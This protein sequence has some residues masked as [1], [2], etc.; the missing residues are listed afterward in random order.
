[1]VISIIFWAVVL[2]SWFLSSQRSCY[3]NQGYRITERYEQVIQEETSCLKM[4]G[5]TELSLCGLVSNSTYLLEQVL[6]DLEKERF[7][8]LAQ[9]IMKKVC[10]W[11]LHYITKHP[12]KPM[13]GL[14]FCVIA[15]YII[16]YPLLTTFAISVFIAVWAYIY[17]R[18]Y[19]GY[20]PISEHIMFYALPLALFG[21]PMIISYRKREEWHWPTAQKC[22]LVAF[23]LSFGITIFFYNWQ[24]SKEEYES[25]MEE[26]FGEDWEDEVK[27][28]EQERFY[29]R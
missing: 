4:V 2:T 26:L 3:V 29:R 24:D 12:K 7:T 19:I 27:E 14:Y 8:T 21:I 6:E 25:E 9:K 1:M 16:C 20:L 22:F 18:N 5:L 13:M 17:V 15:K 11:I 23:W 10:T 28:M